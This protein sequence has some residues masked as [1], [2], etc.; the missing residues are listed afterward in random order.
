MP[1][2]M[3]FHVQQ[4]L[5]PQRLQAILS[6][7]DAVSGKKADLSPLSVKCDLSVNVLEKV[8]LPFVRQLGLLNAA[9]L[10]LTDLGTQ[11]YQFAQQSPALFPEAVHHLLYTAHRFDEGKRFSWAY[12]RV[13]D[14][15]WTSGER[16]LDGGT[17]AQLVGMVVDEASQTF[18][19]PTE[20]I[21]FSRDSVRGALNWL[22]SL[23]PPVV[24]NEGKVDTFRRRYFCPAISLLWAVNFLYRVTSTSYG[25]RMF[26]TSERVEQLCKLCVLDPSGLENVLMVAK[27]M[28]DY[29]RGGV[30]DYGT[31]GGFG[32]WLLL[33]RPCPVPTLPETERA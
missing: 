23:E 15:L 29:D 13:V 2:R 9:G 19:V 21:A 32:W 4:N 14:A 27:R 22:Q 31:E 17:T 25:V 1:K 11:F 3:S 7:A 6:H 33:A 10:S 8:V 24:T 20:Q 30:F 28:S 26:L 18:D 16:T 5:T 12:A